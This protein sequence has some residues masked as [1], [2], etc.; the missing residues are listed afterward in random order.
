MHMENQHQLPTR[1]SKAVKPYTPD[2]FEYHEDEFEHHETNIALPFHDHG[3]K[4]G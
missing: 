1:Q 2:E 3:T 4:R